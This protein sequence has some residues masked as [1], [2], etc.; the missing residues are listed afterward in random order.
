MERNRCR[1][2]W[3]CGL[4][5]SRASND[6]AKITEREVEQIAT[7]LKTAEAPQILKRMIEQPVQ[8]VGEEIA[9][10]PRVV[11][12]E[13]QATWVPSLETTTTTTTV[14]SSPTTVPPASKL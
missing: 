4:W 11:H 1:S 14:P 2:R 9:K 6:A 5:A 12:Q 8:L 3:S 13:E 7:V 10:I